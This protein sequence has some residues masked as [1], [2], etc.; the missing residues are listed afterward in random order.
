MLGPN[1]LKTGAAI[2]ALL[3]IAACGQKT[4][5]APQASDNNAAAHDNAGDTG[6]ASAAAMSI[7][8]AVA[9][10]AR[11]SVDTD[12]DAARK[13]AD[14]LA[15]TGVSSGMSVF[16]MEAGDGYYTELL[17]KIVGPDGEVVMQNPQ[18]FDSFLGDALEQRL[19]DNRLANVRVSRT[20]F[21]SLDAE[22]NSTDLVTWFLGPHELY[23]QR[24]G[25][26]GLGKVDKTYAE[27]FRIMKPGASF[28]VLDHAA[29][30]GTPVETADALHRIDPEA[31]KA[32]AAAAG[33]E[34]AAE[35]DVLRNPDDNYELM[36]FDPAVRRK[37]DRFLLKFTKPE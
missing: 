29:P 5:S 25:S 14:V 37:T 34:L 24:F 7:A 9:S 18:E 31:V 30:A 11:P 3:T 33:L 17:S 15:F 27:I 19:G 10:S 16:E 6:E 20:L 21:D 12:L 13:P 35:S 1:S 4:D 22:D 2:I 32:L 26:W 28:V 8:D 23:Y 36:V